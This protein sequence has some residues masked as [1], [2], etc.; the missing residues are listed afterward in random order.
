MKICNESKQQAWLYIEGWYCDQCN[1]DKPCE[2]KN[3][4][5]N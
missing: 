4:S 2:V 3:E 1:G 5:R